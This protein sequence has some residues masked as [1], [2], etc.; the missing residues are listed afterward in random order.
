MAKK[1]SINVENDEIVSVEV[2][3]VRYTNV[4]QIPDED[5]RGKMLLL[6]ESWPGEEWG[7]PP[8]EPWGLPKVIVPLF[9][10][11]AL[12]MLAIAAIAGVSAGRTLSRERT[13]PGRVVDL[14][15]RQDARG[16]EFYYPLVEF[17][18]P[19]GSRQ[20]VQLT[21]GHWPA[22][23]EIGQEV[24]V[25][26]NPQQSSSARIKTASSTIGMWTVSIIT[27]VLG[28]AFLAATLFA[29]WVLKPSPAEV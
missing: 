18:L 23:Y 2:D 4:D 6:T 10:A 12:L 3:G 21:V 5:D 9:L 1:Y 26:Y 27:G 7:L 19:D 29:R 15:L 14:I 16:S 11:I 25:A 13:A 20:R 28:L 8:R 22:A 24:T 17:D